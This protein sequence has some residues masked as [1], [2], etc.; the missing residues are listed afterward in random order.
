MRD[1]C[2]RAGSSP[3]SQMVSS[4]A[5]ALKACGSTWASPP[6]LEASGPSTKSATSTCSSTASSDPSEASELAG[7]A[8]E[9]DSVGPAEGGSSLEAASSAAL[10]RCLHWCLELYDAPI[11]V[12]ALKTE[13]YNITNHN[14][15]S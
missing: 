12:Q 3:S 11:N 15:D 2:F 13:V 6:G 14:R 1:H 9:A 10:A 5:K 4:R 8:P 7:P